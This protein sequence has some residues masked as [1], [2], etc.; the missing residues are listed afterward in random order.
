MQPLFSNSWAILFVLSSVAVSSPVYNSRAATSPAAAL[1][2]LGIN[3]T[4]PIPVGDVSF[5][6]K[7]FQELF[8]RNETFSTNSAFY[9][10]LYEIPWYSLPIHLLIIFNWSKN[11][12]LI[13]TIG[14]RHVGWSR[15]A[16]RLPALHRTCLRL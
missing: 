5:T 13:A 8:P 12:M 2:G 10:P 14:L 9:T 1:A 7:I 11:G 6:C 15:P 3:S 4:A 16:S